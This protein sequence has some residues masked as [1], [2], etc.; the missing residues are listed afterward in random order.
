MGIEASNISF[1][2]TKNS[3]LLLK[4]VSIEI[5]EGEVVALVGPSGYGK[6]TLAKILSG[7]E[8]PLTGDILIDKK[9]LPKSGAF[10]VQLIYQHPEKAINPRFKM[11]QV[12]NEANQFDNE[13]LGKLGIQNKWLNRYPSE[14]SGGELQRF[15]IARALTSNTKYLIADEIS[16][17]L[18]AITSARLWEVIL[19]EGKKRN[20]GILLITHNVA[21]ANRICNRM[22]DIRDMNEIEDMSFSV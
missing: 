10:P 20:M 13:L 17:M 1:R 2:Y 12:L 9:A 4:N 22:I 19:D 5:R 21:L 16:T 18:D 14:L 8:L 15:C 11:K 7:Y 6:S 3:S